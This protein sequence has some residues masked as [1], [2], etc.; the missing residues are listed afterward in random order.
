M[1]LVGFYYKNY[2]N[3]LMMYECLSDFSDQLGDFSAKVQITTW[4][5]C[6]LG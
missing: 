1:H 2:K 6:V 5:C 4:G 3:Y